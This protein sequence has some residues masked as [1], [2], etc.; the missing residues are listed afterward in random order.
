[1]DEPSVREYGELVDLLLAVPGMHDPVFR[2][3]MYDLLPGAVRAQLPRPGV[4]RVELVSVTAT[5]WRYRHL[6][7]W[8]ALG[9]ALTLL[10]P[11]DPAVVRLLPR[12]AAFDGVA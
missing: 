5:L 9:D 10:A 7:T 1:M 3:Q 12:L 4:A 8:Q 2:Q 11:R 6:R